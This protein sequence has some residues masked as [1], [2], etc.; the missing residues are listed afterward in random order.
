[1]VN[2]VFLSKANRW[3][4]VVVALLLLLA[5][6]LA[7]FGFAQIFATQSVRS[8]PLL[9][10]GP[11]RIHK[12]TPNPI[13]AENQ[14]AGAQQWILTHGS[15]KGEIQAYTS[16]DSLTPGQSLTLHVSTT[17]P[18]F[19][20]EVFRLGFYQGLGA[21]EVYSVQHVPG[22]SQGYYPNSGAP[23][24]GPVNCTTCTI[25]PTTHEVAANWIANSPLDTIHFLSSWVSGLYFIRLTEEQTQRQWGMPVVLRNDTAQADVIMVI[26]FNTYQAYNYWG[27][28]S[29]YH[30]YTPHPLAVEHAYA[31]SYDRPYVAGNGTQFLFSWTYQMVKL[32]EGEGMNVSYT[33]DNALDKGDTKL[34][35][36]YAFVV[37]GHSEYWSYNMR[38]ALTNA[39]VHEKISVAFFSANSIYWQVRMSADGR[40]ILCYKDLY[41]SVIHDPYDTPGNPKRYLTTTLWREAPL[42][43][44]EDQILKEMYGYNANGKGSL[45]GPLQ[46]LVL[47][48][49]ND[50]EYSHTGLTNGTYIHKLLGVEV[51]VITQ[52]GSWGPN[53]SVTVL[54]SSPYVSEYHQLWTQ[55]TTLDDIKVNGALTHQMIF[56][57]GT[58]DW[59]TVLLNPSAEGEALR[60]ISWNVLYGMIYRTTQIP[61]IPRLNV[62]NN[63]VAIAAPTSGE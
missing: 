53:D 13:P 36:Y 55:S 33:T 32:M 27:G 6:V 22:L 25:D 49:T 63:N 43:E 29:L 37:S 30:D 35:N 26:P 15:E 17:A 52:D 11:T 7:G 2:K 34:A 40:T 58:I 54:A 57:A 4:T 59:S 44:P 12:S 42:S 51:D 31:V 14:L 10:T 23:A 46:N 38:Q 18:A 62:T 20:I 24:H 60:E 45:E 3:L 41:P 5:I 56:D 9:I 48:N 19:T 50:W 8:T 39:I 1:M 61:V 47:T 21:R 16:T 28:V